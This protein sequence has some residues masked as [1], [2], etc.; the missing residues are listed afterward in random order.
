MYIIVRL[1]KES[2]HIEGELYSPIELGDTPCQ[3]I[4]LVKFMVVN[5]PLVYNV[6]IGRPTL[7]SIRDVAS[8]Y[9][10]LVKFPIIGG[11]GVLKGQQHKSHHLYVI[12]T[13]QAPNRAMAKHV[14]MIASGQSSQ[15]KKVIT[16][17]LTIPYVMVGQHY[18][19]KN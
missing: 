8:T 11:I 15:V 16:K 2:V 10:M 12:A 13:K 19:N 9:H 1:F 3:H 4:Q 6:I 14:Q 17:K 18:V 7:N 5:C